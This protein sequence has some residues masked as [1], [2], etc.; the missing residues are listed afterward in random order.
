MIDAGPRPPLAYVQLAEDQ[1]GGSSNTITTSGFVGAIGAG[2]SIICQ[3]NYGSV[4]V[5]A[6]K[7]TDT[8]P[9]NTYAR[10]GSP[11]AVGNFNLEVWM[12]SNTNAKA[13]GT[14][15]TAEL[16]GNAAQRVISCFHY[17]AALTVVPGGVRS[18]TF[19]AG[20][21]H[22][23]APVNTT[24]ARGLAFALWVPTSNSALGAGPN[25]T[26]RSRIDGDMIEDRI[27][28]TSGTSY[29]LSAQCSASCA[30]LGAV[31]TAP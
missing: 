25:F 13:A 8:A 9:S 26:V 12:A 16:S 24:A 29:T 28:N 22:S 11:Y 17:N 23:T 7:L 30:V 4:D 14:V 10:I 31:L 18:E 1:A 5:T 27:F 15:V 3:I 20:G 21:N 2:H 6:T 19:N